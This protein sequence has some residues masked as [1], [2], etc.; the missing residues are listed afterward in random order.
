M[1]LCTRAPRITVS[2]LSPLL[3]QMPYKNDVFVFSDTADSIAVLVS[4]PERF[5][6]DVVRTYLASKIHE[7]DVP[8]TILV[9]SEVPRDS[10]TGDV[11]VEACLELYEEET[12]ET[13]SDVE[14][15]VVT[16]FTEVLGLKR[17]VRKSDDFFE[18]GGTSLA[19]GKVGALIRGKLGVKLPP[20][21]LFKYRTIAKFSEV[22][23][24]KLDSM[25][26][27]AAD[28]VESNY[29]KPFNPEEIK[30]E[31]PTRPFALLIQSLSLFL[32]NPLRTAIFCLLFANFL[33][34][35]QG[36][37]FSQFKHAPRGTLA[38]S[39]WILLDIMISIFSTAVV[40]GFMFPAICLA[41]KWLIIGKYKAGSYPL[42]G[43]YYLRWW[44]V[45]QLL[46]VFGMGFFKVNDTGKTL[47]FRMMGAQIGW[48]V[49]F[50]SDSKI[51][52][53]DLIHIYPDCV[54]VTNR[55][56]AFTMEAGLM[57]LKPITLGSNCVINYGCTLAPGCVIPANTV[58]PPLSSSYEINESSQN[59]R[60]FASL[61]PSS[62]NFLS[63]LFI[64]YPIVFIVRLW[65]LLPWLAILYW[66]VQFPFLSTSDEE[67]YHTLSFFGQLITHWG[68]S[69]RISLHVLGAVVKA[70]VC[71]IF[72]LIGTILVKRYIIGKFEAG[73]RKNTQWNL[74][75]HWIM[76]ALFVEGE[77]MEVY[78]LLGRHYEGISIIYRLLGAKI[79][80]RVYWPGTCMKFHELDLLEV[81]N[82]VV[83]GSRSKL[84]FSDSVESR[85]I[86]IDDGAMIADR[87]VVLPGVTVGR[88]AMIG[89]GSL[90][91]KNGY[92]PPGST[93]IGSKNGDA[94]LWEEGDA[95]TALTEPTL[96][97]FGR[98]FCMNQAN[99]TVLGQLSIISYNVIT[100]ALTGCAWVIPPLCGVIVTGIYFDPLAD[101]PLRRSDIIGML[102]F[103]VSVLVS[104]AVLSIFIFMLP[105]CSKW[106]LLGH[107]KTG[108]HDWDKSSYCQRWQ[109]HI[110]IQ[111]VL[112]KVQDQIRGSFYLVA[113]FRFLGAKIGER[114]C[115][116]PTGADPM[117]TEPELVSI[118]DHTVVDKASIISHI[119]TKGSFVLNTLRIGKGCSLRTDSR[120]LSGAEMN[121]GSQLLEHTLIVGG[122]VVESGSVMQGWPAK[123]MRTSKTGDFISSSQLTLENSGKVSIIS[124]DL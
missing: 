39:M 76:N 43:S 121:D 57:I 6:S 85:K 116:Y 53:F 32:F 15:C 74:L 113:Y 51:R 67:S 124:F 101:S 8:A 59:H 73:Q 18:L 92:Y 54:I 107:L 33:C 109:I 5:S 21:A 75:Q 81:G 103:L 105:M 30:S 14:E 62:P 88:N 58:L 38:G 83:F 2:E 87:C 64:G 61:G 104:Y 102:I 120:L 123:E 98:G 13:L 89:S 23:Q 119:N 79:G 77:F 84:S 110:S 86:K 60:I 26:K 44:I 36:D 71:P 90:L 95:S 19:A 99:Y 65:S 10:E 12:R 34:F 56:S 72:E 69:Y 94:L 48:N 50:H 46:L 70:T 112:D 31:S 37:E 68:K 78:E 24:E 40:C 11:D 42:W 118:G 20:M 111:K 97:P 35:F 29:R 25:K 9:V 1:I 91:C 66:L 106:L 27:S 63:L 117:M 108:N 122:E 49:R 3:T 22:I 114:V 115:L 28:N 41:G 16:V 82:D 80:K 52:E 45:D 100:V 17:R 96:K 55:V 4:G 47:F 93:W 7:Y